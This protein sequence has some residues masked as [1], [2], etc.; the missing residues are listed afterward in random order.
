MEGAYQQN[1]FLKLRRSLKPVLDKLNLYFNPPSFHLLE[2]G[3]YHRTILIL[4][5]KKRCER[6]TGSNLN[7][8]GQ[9]SYKP[10]SC[11]MMWP[12]NHLLGSI[13]IKVTQIQ[14]VGLN[15]CQIRCEWRWLWANVQI[16]SVGGGLRW[17]NCILIHY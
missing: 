8:I 15:R 5:F 11:S 12:W 2:W 7:N 16:W 13:L 17:G 10:K 1:L 9:K 6:D 3:P 14:P 4:N